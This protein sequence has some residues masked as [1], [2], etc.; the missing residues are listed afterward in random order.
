MDHISTFR[1][2][3]EDFV[4]SLRTYSKVPKFIREHQLWKGFS[5]H[6]LVAIALIGIG[7]FFGYQFIQTILAWWSQLEVHN[8]LDL[9]IQAAGLV[10]D[11]VSSSYRFLFAGAYKYI[12]LIIM[13]LLIFHVALRTNEIV[14]GRKEVLTTG[15][16]LKAQVRMIKVSVFTYA[17]ELIASIILSIILSLLG[18]KFLKIAL[19]FLVQCFFL[20]F[21]M[22]DN[23]NEI[24]RLSIKDSFANTRHFPGASTGI[25]LIMY[26][27]MLV[28]LVGPLL[29]PLTGAVA[30]TI[31]MRKLEERHGTMVREEEV[32]HV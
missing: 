16:F 1:Y 23:Y 6:K 18:L 20:G 21:A 29:G 12:V 8:P 19:L 31:T 14:T 15:V 2:F 30:A 27:L 22:L 32:D 5:E 26:L 10:G 13:E 7:L 9:G 17:M 28:P 25:G 3:I 24:N 11:V 4:F